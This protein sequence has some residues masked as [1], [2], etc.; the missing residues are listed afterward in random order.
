LSRVEKVG[1]F[2]LSLV[3]ILF[4]FLHLGRAITESFDI[5]TIRGYFL[6]YIFLMTLP[7]KRC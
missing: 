2:I 5:L 4:H 7:K 1:I 6:E 3:K